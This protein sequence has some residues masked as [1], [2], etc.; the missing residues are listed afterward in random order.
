MEEKIKDKLM[1][2][3]E[4]SKRGV[5]G[6]KENAE[7]FLNRMLKK[8]NLTIEDIA[9]EQLKIR[10]YLY[11]TLWKKKIICQVIARVTNRWEIFA[12]S[13]K[14]FKIVSSK[15]TDCEH[16]QILELIDFHFENFELEKK[17]FLKD[18]E[19]AYIQK[20][21]LF[22]DSSDEE[23]KDLTPEERREV[24]RMVGIY[25]NLSN[26]TYTKKLNQ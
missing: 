21:R 2:L 22:K 8:H 13:G 20:H 1:K 3:Y 25:E 16:V 7:M 10:G 24:M 9:S 23:T 6:E 5:G 19:G 26:R 11:T 17:V 15:V 18:F 14:G 12:S 4:L